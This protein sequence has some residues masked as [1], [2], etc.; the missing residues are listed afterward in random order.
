MVAKLTAWKKNDGRCAEARVKC[1]EGQHVFAVYFWHSEGWT[2]CNE[3]LMKAVLRRVAI[4]KNLFDYSCDS[5]M[6]PRDF[7][8]GHW[9]KEAK[10]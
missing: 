8:F 3:E 5:N 4:T 1:H 9:Y 2:V 10:A 6:E 7:Q